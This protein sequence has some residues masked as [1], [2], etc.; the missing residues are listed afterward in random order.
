MIQF[1][2]LYQIEQ[3][4]FRKKFSEKNSLTIFLILHFKM[5]Q[6]DKFYFKSRKIL[7]RIVNYDKL[8]QCYYNF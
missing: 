8:L 2:R 3:N 4:I 1:D 7:Q 5:I 6:F